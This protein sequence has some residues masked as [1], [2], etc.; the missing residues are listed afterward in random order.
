MS[1]HNDPNN[2]GVELN[3]LQYAALFLLAFFDAVL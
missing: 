1:P 2:L 3:N